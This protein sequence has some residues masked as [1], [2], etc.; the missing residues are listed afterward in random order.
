M[1]K[2]SVLL[3]AM[4]M[5]FSFAACGG[6]KDG[7]GMENNSPE[8]VTVSGITAIVP[9]GYTYTDKYEMLGRK[10][11]I[12][13]KEVPDAGS[14]ESP[15]VD[16]TIYPVG[17]AGCQAGPSSKTPFTMETL[18]KEV[19]EYSRTI[20]GIEILDDASFAGYD[21]YVYKTSRN[22]EKCNFYTTVINDRVVG[23][24]VADE[25]FLDTEEAQAIMESLKFDIEPVEEEE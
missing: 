15:Y 21:W 11:L 6:A 5:A 7:D 12:I 20:S 8:E 14:V 23:V 9:D 2:L 1:K 13:C 22:G 18:K 10:N 24:N 4:I 3:L 17:S 16:V 25:I 19:K